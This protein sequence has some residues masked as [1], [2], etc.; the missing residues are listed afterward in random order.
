[1]P[2]LGGGELPIFIDTNNASNIQ[3]ENQLPP[4]NIGASFEGK[5][6]CFCAWV[7]IFFGCDLSYSYENEDLSGK[8]DVEW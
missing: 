1:M 2:A 6:L 8:W 4:V 5:F 3:F 7:V